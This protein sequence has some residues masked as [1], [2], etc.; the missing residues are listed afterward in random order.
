MLVPGEQLVSISKQ[1]GNQRL[2]TGHMGW[3]VWVGGYGDTEMEYTQGWTTSG[4][5]VES[6]LLGAPWVLIFLFYFL[7]NLLFT[8]HISSE[9]IITYQIQY[10]DNIMERCVIFTIYIYVIT[11][12]KYRVLIFMTDLQHYFH[13]YTRHINKLFKYIKYNFCLKSCL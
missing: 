6:T 13:T 5:L 1:G 11:I 9:Y 3:R 8:M 2:R 4:C 7:L 12:I 10:N